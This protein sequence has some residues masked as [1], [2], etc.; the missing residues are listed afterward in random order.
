MKNKKLLLIC[1]VC[2]CLI[3]CNKSPNIE[4]QNKENISRI[5]GKLNRNL[6]NLHIDSDNLFNPSNNN[7]INESLA[8]TDTLLKISNSDRRYLY[9]LIKSK[10]LFLNKEKEESIKE[11]QNFELANPLL[12]NYFYGIINELSSSQKEALN[13]YLI[14]N[15]F[16]INDYDLLCYQIQFLIDNDVDKFL[17][18]LKKLDN[19]IFVAYEQK[20]EE[21]ITIDN[22]RKNIIVNNFFDQFILPNDDGVEDEIKKYF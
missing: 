4:A 11:L 2:M 6:I 16:C 1:L 22:F 3:S 21:S 9:S 15:D 19:S 13:K 14:A 20:L 8:Y 12:Y 18:S 5:K 7:I 17:S 10:L